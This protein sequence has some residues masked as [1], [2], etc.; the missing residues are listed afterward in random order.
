MTDWTGHT[1]AT[2]EPAPN[3]AAEAHCSIADGCITCGD[4]AVP[5]RVLAIAHAPGLALC[6]DESGRRETVETALVEPVATGEVLLVHAGTAISKL[7]DDDDTANPAAA[8]SGAH[9]E[10]P[11][12]RRGQVVLAQRSGAS[13]PER[14]Q[15]ADQQ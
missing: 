3:D 9:E 13:A 1:A 10:S 4:L 2:P 14:E 15:P 11:S 5:L 6:A 8:E 7:G 12:H